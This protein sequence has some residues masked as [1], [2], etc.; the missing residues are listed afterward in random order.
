MLARIGIVL[1][2]SATISLT[3]FVHAV[4]SKLRSLVPLTAVLSLVL[5]TGCSLCLALA[6][7]TYLNAR[8]SMSP[9]AYVNIHGDYVA[10]YSWGDRAGVVFFTIL[11]GGLLCF[12]LI[13]GGHFRPIAISAVLFCGMVYCTLEVTGTRVRF[14]DQ[15]FVARVCW[16]RHL[17]AGY[18]DV[19]SVSGKPTTLK[20][21]FSNG[22]SLKFHPGLG[23]PDKVTAY[24]Q[25]RCPE[26]VD[27]K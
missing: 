25:A 20:I 7:V 15:G 23:N 21:E 27:F 24:L 26:S 17:S 9:P 13:R 5:V 2:A 19:Q 4:S 12:F 1:A 10:E 18:S 14:T 8:R 22:R 16:F 3:L 11:C 6:L